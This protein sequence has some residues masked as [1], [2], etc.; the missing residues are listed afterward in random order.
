M[1]KIFEYIYNFF[2]WLFM[3]NMTSSEVSLAGAIIVR[4]ATFAFT[5][6]AIGA[7]FNC[8]G[9]FNSKAMK[10]VYF[11]ISTIVSFAL[12]YIVKLIETYWQYILI[13]LGVIICSIAVIWSIKKEWRNKKKL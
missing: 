12:C 3:L 9:W 8:L 11:V 6:T 4:F 7:L 5:Y 10:L 1:I 13:A 2:A